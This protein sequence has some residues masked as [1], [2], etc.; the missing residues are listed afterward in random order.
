[1]PMPKINQTG[2]TASTAGISGGKGGVMAPGQSSAKVYDPAGSG[3]RP[4]ASRYPIMTSAPADP[5]TRG[6]APAGYLKQTG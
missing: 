3:S 1:M 4:V 6:A 5:Y 2:G